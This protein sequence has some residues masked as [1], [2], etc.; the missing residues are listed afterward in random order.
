MNLALQDQELPVRLRFEHPLSDEELL[1]FCAA[2]EG[3]RVERDKNGELIV[4]TPT[5]TE[6][7]GVELDVAA[8]LRDWARQEGRGRAFGP[9]AGVRVPDGSIRVADASWISWS[10]WNALSDKER[11]GFA[12]ICPEFVIEVRSLTDRI[13]ELREKMSMWLANGAELAWLIDPERKAVEVYRPGRAPEVL[14][15]MSAVYGE[16]PVGGFVL[17]LRRIWS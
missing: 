5:G 15:G 14:E 9:N 3:L 16:G 10:R 12:P 1:R 11:Q 7:G 4:M 6:G 2:N 13:H 17:E 8:E